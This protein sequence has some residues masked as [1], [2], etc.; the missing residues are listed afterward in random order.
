MLLKMLIWSCWQTR[1]PSQSLGFDDVVCIC[2]LS[3][4][5]DKAVLARSELLYPKRKPLVLCPG[6]LIVT[7]RTPHDWCDFLLLRR[8]DFSG[9]HFVTN[10]LC[11]LQDQ[12][13]S[14][15][16]SGWMRRIPG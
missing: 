13:S 2:A 6:F 10:A 11:S 12:F 9:P 7:L 14:L 1:C 3:P 4:T 15:D 16:L 5:C 8:D